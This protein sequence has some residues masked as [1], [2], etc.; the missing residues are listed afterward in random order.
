MIDAVAVPRRVRIALGWAGVAELV[1]RGSALTVAAQFPGYVA[2]W[3]TLSAAAVL[4]AGVTASRVGAD[5]LLASRPLRYLGGCRRAALFG[6][7][8]PDRAGGLPARR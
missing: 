1:G 4:I 7:A 2:L 6:I 3:P 5:R 8:A